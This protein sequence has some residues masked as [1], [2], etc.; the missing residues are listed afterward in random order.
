M[1]DKLNGL[2]C[3]GAR[4][5]EHALSRTLE[6]LV[7]SIGHSRGTAALDGELAVVTLISKGVACALWQTSETYLLGLTSYLAGDNLTCR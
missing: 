2:A 5:S 4:P 6:I 1:I 3:I 7:K